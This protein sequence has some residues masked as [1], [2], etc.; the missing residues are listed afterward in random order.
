MW[1]DVEGEGEGEEGDGGRQHCFHSSRDRLE[2]PAQRRKDTPFSPYSPLL[3]GWKT[4][5]GRARGLLGA[6]GGG[7]TALPH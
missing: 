6:S 3:S 2:G 4:G 5:G 7:E 1:D